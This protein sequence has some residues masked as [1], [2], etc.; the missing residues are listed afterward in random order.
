MSSHYA[1]CTSSDRPCVSSHPEK[2]RPFAG[3]SLWIAFVLLIIGLSL[4]ACGPER[5]KSGSAALAEE[6]V[7][8]AR[9]FG[10]NNDAGQA[11]A[12]L[13]ALE[14]ANPLQWLVYLAETA[15]S[16]GVDAEETADLV[17]LAVAF[18]SQSQP[19][20]DYA[21][22]SGMIEADSVAANDDVVEAAQARSRRPRRRSLSLCRRWRWSHWNRRPRRRWLCWNRRL[23]WKRW[24]LSRRRRLLP[25]RIAVAM[26]AINVRSGPG[27]AYPIVEDLQTGEEAEIVGKNPQ[28]DWWQ[29][30]SAGGQVGW[31]FGQLV[32]TTGDVGGVA[33][34]ANIPE[35][36]P[37][38]TPAPVAETPAEQ[39]PVQPPAENPAPAEEAPA[40]NP[41]PP[42]DGPDFVVIEKRLWD[43]Y[44][45]GGSLNGPSVVC[46]EK[47]QL[48]VNVVDANGSR[49][50]GVAVQ[51]EFGAKIYVTGAQGKGDGVVEFVLGK[52]PGCPGHS[53]DGRARGGLRGR[54][55]DEH[56]TR[57]DPL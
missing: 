7:R 29:V 20:L 15:V 31:V 30:S 6:T 14:V 5:D 49:I 22:E 11:R 18:G 10:R 36:P 48:V 28:A 40:E 9:E 53:Q 21:L 19:I 8:I 57:R 24:C 23:R 16:S 45:N 56:R 38:P 44:E 2:Q 27:T 35:P 33:V 54:T 4:T 25:G 12:D 39:P 47:R 34:A 3:R 1:S 46:G 52:R 43:V 50:N 55:R 51:A 32:A 42:A 17:R 26:A 13:Q 41:A 37:T